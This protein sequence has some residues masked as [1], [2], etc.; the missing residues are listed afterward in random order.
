MT[1]FD[2]FN[3]RLCRNIRNELSE[4]LIKAVHNRDI[5]P[6]IAVA[7]KYVSQRA[8]PFIT[9][10]ITNR[11]TCYKTVLNQI[12][13]ADIKR[14]DTFIIALLLWDQELFFEFHEWLE[15]KW[16]GSKGIDKMILQALIRAAGAYIHMEH[17]RIAGARKMASKAAASLT[18]YKRFVPP[19]L[20]VELLVSKLK[21][22][23]AAP[24]KLGAS[25]LS[26]SVKSKYE[27][28]ETTPIR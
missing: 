25:A 11:I 28:Q 19:F 15:K 5:G 16:R 20:N 21:A 4:S 13:S 2:P 14:H 22:L 18:R 6:S 7:E 12:R 10:Y 3:S 8:E 23:D 1:N 27:T 24:P 26:A 17:G 9:R